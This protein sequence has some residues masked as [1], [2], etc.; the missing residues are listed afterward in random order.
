MQFE[1]LHKLKPKKYFRIAL[2]VLAAAAAA[3][4]AADA[5][6]QAMNTPAS[7]QFYP[8]LGYWKG[9]GQLSVPGKDPELLKLSLS[10]RKAV[11][12]F[13][14]RCDLVGRSDTMTFVEADLMAVDP[15]T[16]V[17]HW[18][19]VNNQG[20]T[21]D[22]I[23]QWPDA[24]TMNAHYEWG[25]NGKQMSENAVFRFRDGKHMSFRSVTTQDGQEVGAF[26]G[27]MYR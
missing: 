16:G 18:Y 23:A 14:V 17:G 4:A 19:A 21:H 12:G 27:N 3:V 11:A 13:A 10:C 20:E 7:S 15:V 2:L 25:Q 24:A 6:A 9:N 22:H 5:T 8:F 1:A 26:F